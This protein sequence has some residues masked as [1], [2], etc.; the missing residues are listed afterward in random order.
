M[1]SAASQR[2]RCSWCW[3]VPG[4]PASG[5]PAEWRRVRGSTWT[6]TIRMHGLL[7]PNSRCASPVLVYPSIA[8]NFLVPSPD[9]KH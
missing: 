4:A 9:L 6:M 2:G 8:C 5:S 1:C 3:F 7:A